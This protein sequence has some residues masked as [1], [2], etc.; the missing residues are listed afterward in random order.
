LTGM[1]QPRSF[2]GM[3]FIVAA[4][5]VVLFGRLAGHSQEAI[6]PDSG[7]ELY[8]GK[9]FSGW[10]FYMR[11]NAAPEKTWS[12]TNGMVHCTGRPAGYMRTERTYRD[13]KVTVEWRFPKSATKPVNTGVLVF[14]QD[15]APDA[16]PK[17][18][19]PHCVECQGLHDHM[20]DFWLQ[21]GTSCNET[22]NLGKNGIKMLEPSNESPVGEWTTFSCLC[23][24]NTVEII[25]NGK[26]MNKITGVDVSAGYI[27]IQSEGGPFDLRKVSLEPL[28]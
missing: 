27:G 21:G 22:V 7:R 10:T 28:P 19:W 4:F 12:I 1:W 11:S 2:A 15:R 23:R 18:V 5:V 20:G 17:Q 14:M 16:S 8:D 13:F 9:D 3:K 25:V 24:T 6:A 26:S